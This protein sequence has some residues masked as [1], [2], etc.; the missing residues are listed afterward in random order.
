MKHHTFAIEQSVAKKQSLNI[1]IQFK[2]TVRVTRIRIFLDLFYPMQES[3]SN[4][5]NSSKQV[6]L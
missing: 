5:K 2:S 1:L 3:L 4:E 6:K